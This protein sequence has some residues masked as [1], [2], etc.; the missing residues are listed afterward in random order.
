MAPRSPRS[1]CPPRSR[2]STRK[3]C[4]T[5][6]RCW[7][8]T[9][10]IPV[11]SKPRSSRSC[12]Q[13]VEAVTSTSVA[14]E[15]LEQLKEG[16]GFFRIALLV[17]GSDSPESAAREIALL[18]PPPVTGAPVGA[19][20]AAGASSAGVGPGVDP[21]ADAA[22]APMAADSAFGVALVTL[23]H[24]VARAGGGVGFADSVE[25]ADV[26]RAAV[27]VVEDLRKGR[28]LGVAADQPPA[29]R[30]AV[31]HPGSGARAHTGTID[32]LM[33]EPAL[34]G[35]GL[36]RGLIEA[37]WTAPAVAGCSG[38][39]SNSRR[40]SGSSAS[41]IG[42]VS[43][44]GAAGRAGSAPAPETAT[45]SSWEW[46]CE[47]G[48]EEKMIPGGGR[49][50]SGGDGKGGVSRPGRVVD[51][52]HPI[53]EGDGDLPGHSRSDARVAPD[54]RRVGRALCG[55]HRVLDRHHLDGAPT[56]AP[57]WTRRRIGTGT[58]EDLSQV[59]PGEDG[60]PARRRG[61]RPGNGAPS[62][63]AGDRRERT[64]GRARL[65]RPRRRRRSSSKPGTSDR[66]GTP[67]Y[68]ADHP[69][70]TD[71]AV[72]YLVSAKRALVGIDSLNIDSTHTGRRPRTAGCWPPGS[73]WWRSD[74]AGR[75]AGFRLPVHR[76]ATGGPGD[77]DLPGAGVRDSRLDDRFQGL[78][79]TA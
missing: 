28:A 48:R 46:R 3:G 24:E 6:S 17:Y 61:T 57:T 27:P 43:P 16:L 50:G 37:R 2:C 55:R 26:A 41:S 40:T 39:A 63:A 34:T 74:R 35:C 42:S 25:R 15:Q 21:G 22:S 8:T 45:R 60:G 68:F 58:G 51:L 44:C 70:L 10:W 13:K 59:Q 14:E 52:S 75:P 30:A 67:E 36:G 66:W 20:S 29:G 38:S 71:D 31:L 11:S 12:P 32:L 76:R 23:W 19:W 54:V 79:V 73:R 56:P 64:C 49:G 33:V 1:T 78:L 65:R 18:V 62:A 9:A 77:G 72:E 7:G 53:D 4:S 69:Y 5:R 47:R